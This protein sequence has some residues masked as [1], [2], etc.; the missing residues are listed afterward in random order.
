M[1]RLS[2]TIVFILYLLAFCKA[3]DPYDG[4]FL[5][6]KNLDTTYLELEC[7]TGDCDVFFQNIILFKNLKTLKITRLRKK[8]HVKYLQFLPELQSLDLFVPKVSERQLVSS[9]KSCTNLTHL[10]INRG[11]ASRLPSNLK[12]LESLEFVGLTENYR[13]YYSIYNLSDY[14][15]SRKRPV[16][17]KSY[18]RQL[19]KLHSLDSLDISQNETRIPT[20]INRLISLKYLDLS[21]IPPKYA[22]GNPWLRTWIAQGASLMVGGGAYSN[23]INAINLDIKSLKVHS[24]DIWGYR[25][26]GL[27]PKEFLITQ[28]DQ[29]TATDYHFFFGPFDIFWSTPYQEMNSCAIIY[30]PDTLEKTEEGKVNYGEFRTSRSNV[31]VKSSAYLYYQEFLDK[32]QSPYKVDT[33]SFSDRYSDLRY[34]GVYLNLFQLMKNT[35][36]PKGF[37][38]K[39]KVRRQYNKNIDKIAFESRNIGFGEI[40]VTFKK[41]RRKWWIG[42]KDNSWESY[43][44]REYPELHAFRDRQW[45]LKHPSKENR[46]KLLGQN[47]TDLR[48][49]YNEATETFMME[50]KSPEGFERFELQIVSRDTMKRQE[51]T[52][53]A[54]ENYNTKLN[55]KERNFNRKIKNAKKRFARVIR[56]DNNRA[57]RQFRRTHMTTEERNMS[58][59]DWERYYKAVMEN[60]FEALLK[61][62]VAI[63]LMARILEMKGY[64]E[65]TPFEW[66]KYYPKVRH[67]KCLFKTK[68]GY[69]DVRGI[70]LIDKTNGSFLR[71][72]GKKNNTDYMPI[73]FPADTTSNKYDILVQ[74]GSNKFALVNDILFE[75]PNAIEPSICQVT[76][77]ITPLPYLLS[78]IRLILKEIKLE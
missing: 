73:P 30:Q 62:K 45:I 50:L 53:R 52:L 57:W 38:S 72:S 58:R 75:G 51:R 41:F 46:R 21:R 68:G 10:S 15:P 64:K 11:F 43:L 12:K 22:T 4:Q 65:L 74:L 48:L 5:F 14:T 54:F 76:F 16:K 44:L 55:R 23:Q 17:Y 33:T 59:S 3:Q 19:R 8:K 78:D 31:R 66:N 77:E 49:D 69:T 40:E 61:S 13:D 47:W 60:E 20:S 27:Y 9:L 39:S 24:G 32:N 70:I 37:E 42:K 67:Y 1:R 56:R 18:F 2:A 34:N 63:P 28:F 35:P 29:L 25:N 71:L 6:L 7:G 36:L 26:V